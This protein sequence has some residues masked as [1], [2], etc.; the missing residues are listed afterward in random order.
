MGYTDSHCHI[1]PG[2]DDGARDENASLEI[3][4]KLIDLGFDTVIA[5]PHYYNHSE[6]VDSFVERRNKAYEK[7]RLF[8][9]LKIV[10]AAEVALESGVS[11]KCDLEKLAIPGTDRI[12]VELPMK[13]YDHRFL[14]EL[15]DIKV[16]H[17]LVPIIAHFERY[18]SYFEADDY[19]ELLSLDGTIFQISLFSLVKMRHRSFFK[20]LYA[21]DVDIIVG[22]DAHKIDFRLADLPKA[23]K[24]LEKIVSSDQ[25]GRILRCE[26]LGLSLP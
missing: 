25:F 2:I 22:T 8:D 16:R 11:K 17:G 19:S 15:F 26:A 1:L 7:V 18:G 10:P 21:T 14:D 23:M 3:A 13:K 5:T 12:L 6:S 9:N 20:R 4:S 24:K